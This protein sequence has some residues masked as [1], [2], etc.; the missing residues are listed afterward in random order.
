MSCLNWPE[1]PCLCPQRGLQN[2]ECFSLHTVLCFYP[3]FVQSWCSSSKMTGHYKWM[4]QTTVGVN[5]FRYIPI[6]QMDINTH[7][8][9]FLATTIGTFANRASFARE[10]LCWSFSQTAVTV[11]LR[12]CSQITVWQHH[13]W[14][15]CPKWVS[16][17][18]IWSPDWWGGERPGKW[19]SWK[20]HEISSRPRN[21]EEKFSKEKRMTM[22]MVLSQSGNFSP[23]ES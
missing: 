16:L 14:S 5:E 3:T 23:L 11:F 22:V 21:D 4:E 2:T 19:G 10:Q 7:R 17:L 18:H 13:G 20:W 15:I 8:L 9:G 12:P 6:C 1:I